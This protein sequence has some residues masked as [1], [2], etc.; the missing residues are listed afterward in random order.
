MCI[1]DRESY[2]VHRRVCRGK[3]RASKERSENAVEVREASAF[4]V[5]PRSRSEVFR[6]KTLA[7]IGHSENAVESWRERLGPA[8]FT[9]GSF[10][11]EEPS[12]R[13]A[14]AVKVREASA[15]WVLPRSPKRFPEGR[16]ERSRCS[17]R[18][19]HT[20]GSAVPLGKQDQ[21]VKT[22]F[23]SRSVHR[24]RSHVRA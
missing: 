23:A 20:Q 24:S 11:R 7:S 8:A 21:E 17:K 1:R 15:F 13:G 3:S 5:L 10:P 12:D 6:G 18:T 9:V 4:C 14:N 2:R 22:H 19:Q 16:A